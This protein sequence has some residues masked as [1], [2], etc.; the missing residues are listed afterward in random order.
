MQRLI[1]LE[2]KYLVEDKMENY[3]DND[4][5][6]LLANSINEHSEH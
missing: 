3:S 2:W 4:Q 5:F 6:S 1:I